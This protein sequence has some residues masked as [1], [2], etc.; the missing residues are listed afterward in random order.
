MRRTALTIQRI[1][2]KNMVWALS[3]SRV[4]T[5]LHRNPLGLA[6]LSTQPVYD[7]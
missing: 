5:T 3:F 2:G 6:P 7:R 1:W 4:D